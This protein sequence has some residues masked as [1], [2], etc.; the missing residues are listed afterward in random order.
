MNL[1]PMNAADRRVVHKVATEAG[2]ETESIGEGRDRY[3]VLRPA[4]KK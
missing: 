3:V 1:K 4:T 2:L